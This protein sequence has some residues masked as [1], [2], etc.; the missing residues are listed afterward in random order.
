MSDISLDLNQF[1]VKMKVVFEEVE[2]ET[3]INSE[4]L[5]FE[6]FHD[7]WEWIYNNKGKF[8]ACTNP[9]IATE[10]KEV[11]TQERAERLCRYAG[12]LLK[13]SEENG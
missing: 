9:T 7:A 12:E 5:V 4:V 6:D 2:N 11:P 3:D 1:I 8:Y 10:I 13:R